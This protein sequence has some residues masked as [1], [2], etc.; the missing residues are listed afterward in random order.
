MYNGHADVTAL[1]TADGKIVASYYYDAFGTALEKNEN[2]GINNPYRYAGYV[3][4]NA[5]SLYYLNARYYDSKIARFMSEDT[6]AGED[7]DPLS[8][9]LYTYC[10]NNPIIYFDPS[11]H[12]LAGDERLNDEAKTQ[13]IALGNAYGAAKTPEEK[14]KIAAMK[15]GKI[16]DAENANAQKLMMI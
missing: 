4:D 6:Y 12:W 8:L 3:Y 7:N 14:K 1:L 11:G 15:D 5:T 9:N 10:Y 13:I 16:T 2:K